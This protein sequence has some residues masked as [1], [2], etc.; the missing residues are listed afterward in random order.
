M[1]TLAPSF[2]IGSP[3]FLQVTRTSFK[4]QIGSKFDKI[5]PRTM[6]L[7]VLEPLEKSLLT[8]NG[9]YA[10]TTYGWIFFILAGNKDNQ[11]S[12]ASL[13]FGIMLSLT[14]ETELAAIERQTN[15]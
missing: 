7:A 14:M 5:W 10:V 8:Y 11:K 6:E 4:S 15:Q 1:T 2:L 9:R 12:W 3:L 13:N